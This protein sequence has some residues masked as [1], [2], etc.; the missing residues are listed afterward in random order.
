LDDVK[1]ARK[2]F[3]EMAWDLQ[4][5]LQVIREADRWQTAFA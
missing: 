5:A 1:E 2:G 3:A 4:W